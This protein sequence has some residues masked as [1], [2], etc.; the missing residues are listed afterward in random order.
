MYRN[1]NKDERASNTHKRISLSSLPE[2]SD[3]QLDEVYRQTHQQND[4]E[5]ETVSAEAKP[6]GN[7]SSV[8]Q[9]RDNESL[10]GEDDAPASAD[11]LQANGKRGTFKRI[12]VAVCVSISLLVLLTA[13]GYFWLL[14]GGRGDMSYQVR[15]PQFS[16]NSPSAID[17]TQGITE[18]EIAREMKK[19]NAANNTSESSRV[20]ATGAQEQIQSGSPIT[21]RLPSDNFSAT[22]NP[23]STAT[24]PSTTSNAP[25]GTGQSASGTGTLGSAETTQA[26]KD[27]RPNTDRSIRVLL[28][29]AESTN[30]TSGSPLASSQNL[31]ASNERQRTSTTTPP[32]SESATTSNSLNPATV[33]VPPLGTMLPVRT[34]GTVFTLRNDSFVRMQLT[35]D[36][37]GS[38]WHLARST[39]FY[40]MLRGAEFG[41][42]RAFV[43]LI[44]FVDA[45]TNRL[46]RLQGN[47]LDKDGADG[48]RGRKHKLDSGWARAL[49]MAGASMVDALSTIA[50]G[51]GRRPVYVGDIYGYAA[52]RATAPLVQEISGIAYGDK[53]RAS[54]FVE[55]PANTSGY[56]LVITTPREIQ[57]T[58]ADVSLPPAELQRL[59]DTSTP[60]TSTLLTE[61]E[62]AELLTSG[63]RDDIR[64]AFPRMSP[65]MQ[66]VAEVVLS[67]R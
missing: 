27:S 7:Q 64:R 54:G 60:R 21:D 16:A 20:V 19:P 58:E 10:L 26:A 22:V 53:R 14:N 61:Q 24:Q 36:V 13:V 9:E 11:L 12:A 55:V 45:S 23:N 46:V 43:S 17:S 66:R 59:S 40:G 49:K 28:L 57:G 31:P 30:S 42:G 33:P 29:Q 65:E 25:N 41:A 35:R 50:A 67:Q 52:P 51:V 3:E 6:K 2:L 44:G 5:A 56:I 15:N 37:A 38:G 34:L 4:E 32:P 8:P 39:E 1:E 48:L 62:L 18:E 47:L 63:S